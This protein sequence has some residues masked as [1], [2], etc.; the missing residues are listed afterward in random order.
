MNVLHSMLSINEIHMTSVK[1]FP[2]SL[3]GDAIITVIEKSEMVA[4]GHIVK[5][6]Q[7]VLSR[8]KHDQTALA[9]FEDQLAVY[10]P[11][12]RISVIWG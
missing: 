3:G 4:G 2:F 6:F 5:C 12:N 7:T 10:V 1:H 11:F 9:R 8:R